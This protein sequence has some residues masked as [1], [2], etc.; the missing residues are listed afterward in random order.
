M[1]LSRWRRTHDWFRHRCHA[2][3]DAAQAEELVPAPAVDDLIRALE[4]HSSCEERTVFARLLSP[5]VA[6]DLANQHLALATPPH[7]SGGCISDDSLVKWAQQLLQHLQVEEECVAASTAKVTS[8]DNGSSSPIADAFP[9]PGSGLRSLAL[10]V[11]REPD[12]DRKAA[13]TLEIS[14]A[15]TSGEVSLEDTPAGGFSEHVPDTPSRPPS[16]REVDPKALRSAARNVRATIHAVVHAESY[17][18]DLSWD[19]IARLG[20]SPSTWTF[21]STHLDKD[22]YPN[23]SNLKSSSPN[24]RM[25]SAFFDDW[26]KV[27]SDEATHYCRWRDRLTALGGAYGLMDAHAMLWQAASETS[28]SLLERLAIVHCVHE[29]RGLDVAPTFAA[30]L[31]AARDDESA[32]ILHRNCAE[33]ETHVATGVR[34]FEFV[35]TAAG[36]APGDAPIVFQRIVRRLHRG[37]LRG[38]FDE[39]ARARAGLTPMWWLP[40]VIDGQTAVQ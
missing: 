30:R 39:D 34:W 20:W 13:L 3:I 17:A 10:S 33:E 5:E 31:A 22:A 28:S 37:G 9:P 1:D 15:Y 35:C 27:A 25:P 7:D 11:L 24:A 29:A 19:I 18:I 32:A 4:R 16:V 23:P 2:I 40:L 12:T 21:E 26:V 36:T 14:R 38:P 8:L 6:A